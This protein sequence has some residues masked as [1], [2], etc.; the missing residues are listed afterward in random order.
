VRCKVA[1]EEWQQ[2]LPDPRA[3]PTQIAIGR[4]LAPGFAS[5]KQIFPQLFAALVEER[6]NDPT[7]RSSH[8]RASHGRACER[9]NSREARQT[10]P[11]KQVHEHCFSLIVRRMRHGDAGRPAFPNNTLEEGVTKTPCGVLK[12]PL[13]AGRHGGHIVALEDEFELALA[14]QIRHKP[15]VSFRFSA[16]KEMVK[17]KD[18][19]RDS[20]AILQTLKQPQQRH[21]IRTAR[22]GDTHTV[23][24]GQHPH[25]ANR[26]Q[27]ALAE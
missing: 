9:I 10:G 25:V 19:Q 16:T 21:R 23:P 6:P 27:N 3:Q 17:M 26:L 8:G 18:E 24:G 11:L 2:A 1:F 22:D 5:P 14:S 7:I 13:A 15:G 12:I 4:I 20:Q